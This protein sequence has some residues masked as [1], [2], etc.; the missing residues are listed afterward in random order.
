MLCQFPMR[1]QKDLRNRMCLV[2]ANLVS[3]SYIQDLTQVPRARLPCSAI[4]PMVLEWTNGRTNRVTMPCS[5][6]DFMS[7]DRASRSGARA[8]GGLNDRRVTTSKPGWKWRRGV[9]CL[10]NIANTAVRSGSRSCTSEVLI[11]VA[12]MRWLVS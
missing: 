12:L 1:H 4:H 7:P 9:S 5:M 6:S 11:N 2:K 3:L 8:R 10:I